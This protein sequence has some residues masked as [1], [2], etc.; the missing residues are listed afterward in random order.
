MTIVRLDSTDPNADDWSSPVTI[1]NDTLFQVHSGSLFLAFGAAAPATG[2]DGLMLTV[3]HATNGR[4][5][6][7]VPTGTN[8]RWR[9]AV[10]K[11]TTVLWY[12]VLGA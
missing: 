9:R 6:V 3:E 11:K 7:I 8:V 1:A 4:D 10:P 2:D 5:S 12:G